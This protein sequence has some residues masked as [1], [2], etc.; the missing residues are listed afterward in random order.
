MRP[1][2]AFYFDSQIVLRKGDAE[3]K[4]NTEFPRIFQLAAVELRKMR[5]LFNE[6]GFCQVHPCAIGRRKRYFRQA[7]LPVRFVSL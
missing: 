7:K 1:N 6:I 2:H 3:I 4:S 5:V